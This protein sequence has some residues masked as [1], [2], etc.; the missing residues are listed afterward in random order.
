MTT[1]TENR[2]AERHA[3]LTALDMAW[4]RKLIPNA[5]SD[6]VLLAAMHKARYEIPSLP[7]E[8]RHESRRW[9]EERSLSRF[10]KLPWPPAGQLEE[11]A[12]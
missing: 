1:D 5:S 8:L 6:D 10:G 4:A 12:H 7:D 3:A 2:Q 9:L 11:R